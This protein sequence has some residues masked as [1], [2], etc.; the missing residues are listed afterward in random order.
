MLLGKNLGNEIE[1]K[2]TKEHYAYNF[3][4]H[5]VSS[6]RDLALID[7]TKAKPGSEVDVNYI[8]NQ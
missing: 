2:Q 6:N 4:L 7:D 1:R 8:P 5:F 3:E